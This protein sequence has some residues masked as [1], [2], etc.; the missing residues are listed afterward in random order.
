GGRLNGA[1]TAIY[2]R[3]GERAPLP[4]Q[5]ADILSSLATWEDEFRA[6]LLLAD[7]LHSP[8]QFLKRQLVDFG[9]P[10]ERISVVGNGAQY[11]PARVQAKRGGRRLR[12]GII[13][14]HRLKGL[15]VLIEA[16]RQLPADAAELRV[17]GQVADQRY[18]DAQRQ[19]AAGH[20]VEFR[21]TYA[22]ADLYS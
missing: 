20:H 11:D 10:A 21:G 22:Q 8:S 4:A 7:R 16:F 12:F 1:L 9:V 19:R 6:A 3:F 18:V 14:M 17:Y 2:E 5:A 13:G 15:H